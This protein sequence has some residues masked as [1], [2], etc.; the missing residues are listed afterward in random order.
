VTG[1]VSVD[2]GERTGSF[3]AYLQRLDSPIGHGSRAMVQLETQM[4]QFPERTLFGMGAAVPG[5]EGVYG[6]VGGTRR[7]VGA[8]GSSIGRQSPIETGGVGTAR[9]HLELESR[10]MIDGGS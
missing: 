7:Y 1:V 2:G 4:F 5:A 9:I 10:E 3:F 6:I 8:S